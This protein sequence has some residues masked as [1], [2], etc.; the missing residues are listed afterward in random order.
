MDEWTYMA[1]LA[2][3]TLALAEHERKILRLHSEGFN[4][5]RI[6]K[7]LKMESSQ[8]NPHKKN[9]LKKNDR[10]RADL[11]IIEELNHG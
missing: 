10:A 3:S 4:D 1:I 9:V 6:A 5:Y 7:K 8:H 2:K 11:D